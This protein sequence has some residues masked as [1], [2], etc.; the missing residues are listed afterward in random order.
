MSLT[1]FEVI[2]RH[3]YEQKP[4]KIDNDDI[5]RAD[6]PDTRQPSRTTIKNVDAT[7]GSNKENIPPP[8]QNITTYPPASPVIYK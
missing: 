4:I 5:F 2:Q 8:P 1:I 6:I 7:D 3:Q